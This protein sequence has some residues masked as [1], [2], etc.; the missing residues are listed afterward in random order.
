MSRVVKVRQE[1][2]ITNAISVDVIT[3]YN[4]MFLESMKSYNSSNLTVEEF[5]SDKYILH[6]KL[7][8]I[9]FRCWAYCE[10]TF[11][12]LKWYELFL[13]LDE[14]R[15]DL[16]AGSIYLYDI[17]WQNCRILCHFLT[18]G[19]EKVTDFVR[20]FTVTEFDKWLRINSLINTWQSIR[21]TLNL[22]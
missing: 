17:H 16:V 10:D 18:Q 14:N 15:S 2:G 9:S 12:K 4:T 5:V 11:N 13:V 7:V 21:K 3:S 22:I 1:S 8:G 19:V 6:E 20:R